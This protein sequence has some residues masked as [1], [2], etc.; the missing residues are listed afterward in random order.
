MVD[1]ATHGIDQDRFASIVGILCRRMAADCRIGEDW[2]AMN[3]GEF[4]RSR[5]KITQ[6]APNSRLGYSHFVCHGR[7]YAL[8]HPAVG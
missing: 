8:L 5:W 6:F 1:K 7:Q 2:P 3:Y 4:C